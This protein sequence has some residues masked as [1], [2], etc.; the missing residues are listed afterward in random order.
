[1]NPP[2][3][4]PAAMPI[5]PGAP[6]TAIAPPI[7]LP[8]PTAPRPPPPADPGIPS[9]AVPAAGAPDSEPWAPA[10][11][12][13]APA[14]PPSPRRKLSATSRSIPRRNS[15]PANR[16]RKPGSRGAASR[17]STCSTTCTAAVRPNRA[18]S[19]RGI[20]SWFSIVPVAS[21]SVSR[22][23]EA[24]DSVSDSVS[25]PSSCASSSTPTSIVFDRSPAP[26]LSVPLAAV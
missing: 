4:G 26:N 25:S 21:P 6:P 18:S 13:V 2:S 11:V 16:P 1:M 24:F 23:D 22:P 3:I 14:I 15:R 9:A 19:A 5:A 7:G 10:P 20:G 8:P 12:G 17:S